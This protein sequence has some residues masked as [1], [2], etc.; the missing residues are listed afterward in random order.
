MTLINEEHLSQPP[1]EKQQL[2][3]REESMVHHDMYMSGTLWTPKENNAAPL[4][5]LIMA[6]GFF[7]DE[8]Q[9]IVQSIA[10]RLVRDL[11]V[12]VFTMNYDP[13]DIWSYTLGHKQSL[14]YTV[15]HLRRFVKKVEAE[16]IGLLGVSYGG[17]IALIAHEKRKAIIC[18]GAPINPFTIMDRPYFKQFTH[19]AEDGAK[20]IGARQVRVASEF[21][22]PIW[23]K[24]R[25]PA[26]I[27]DEI[28]LHEYRTLPSPV[29][30]IHANEKENGLVPA[31]EAQIIYEAVPHGSLFILDRPIHEKMTPGQIHNFQ[32]GLREPM[33]MIIKDA[34]ENLLINDTPSWLMK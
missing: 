20:L 15:E 14:D 31:K 33:L 3:W 28:M 6:P 25:N 4:P 21:E 2:K 8:N 30:L 9:E 16:K 7:A 10:D 29:V 18:L 23:Y 12:A 22:D 24:Q 5:L 1:Y 34:V 11:K 13:D 32:G 27:R 19:P 26:D 17:S